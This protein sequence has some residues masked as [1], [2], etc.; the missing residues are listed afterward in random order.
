M[1]DRASWSAAWQGI[2]ARTAG[3]DLHRRL[4]AAWSEG[5]R[6][7]H[8]LQHLRECLEHLQAARAQAHRPDEIAV[9]LWFH[10]AVYEPQRED[11]EARSAQWLRASAAEDGVPQA[12]LERLHEMVMATVDHMPRDGADTQLLVD[13]DLSIL[14]ADPARFDE[15]NHQ[16]RRE[17]GHVPEPEWKPGRRKVLQGFLERPRLYGTERFHAML[18]ARARD[19]LARELANL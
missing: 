16:I 3:E 11:N 4:V 13:I 17:Y 10:D 7:Y 18:E 15:S 6:H 5:Q 2:G 19:N 1:I 9:A 14:G 12:A 8:T